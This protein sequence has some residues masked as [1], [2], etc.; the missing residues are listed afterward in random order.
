MSNNKT[1]VPEDAFKFRAELV[2]FAPVENEGGAT[3]TFNITMLARSAGAIE[4]WYWGAQTVHDLA[5]MTV[6]DRI[7]ID[8]NHEAE[9]I[10]VLDKFENT[11]EGLRVS[12]KLVSFREDDRAAEIAYKASQGVPWQASINFG[13]DGIQVEQVD[14]GM[15]ATANGQTFNG[16]ATIIR[17]WP[18]RGVAVTPYGADANTE[19]MV[20]RNSGEVA[21]EFLTEGLTMADENEAVEVEAVADTVIAED[22]AAEIADDQVVEGDVEASQDETAETDELENEPASDEEVVE[23]EVAEPA[24]LN[25]TAGARFIELFGERGA[26]WFIEGKTELECFEL[27]VNELRQQVITLG[28]ENAQLSAAVKVFDRGEDEAL[29]FSAAPSEQSEFS[30]K[31]NGYKRQNLNSAASYFAAKFDQSETE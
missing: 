26:V 18:L 16:P 22:N 31:V 23:A 4:H 1:N 12:G 3:Q 15:A 6:A 19:S 24:V 30:E 8:F 5:G 25:A 29:T 20:L 9:V 7:P 2:E 21:V 13:G 10:G 28:D 27:E 14:E 11:P 17:S